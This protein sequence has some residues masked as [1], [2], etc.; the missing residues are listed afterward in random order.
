MK[1]YL[2]VEKYMCTL[3][4]IGPKFCVFGPGPVW[5]LNWSWAEWVWSVDPWV[6]GDMVPVLWTSI[7][8]VISH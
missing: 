3:S 2:N 5:G 6:R 1:V 4:Q 7:G 8:L